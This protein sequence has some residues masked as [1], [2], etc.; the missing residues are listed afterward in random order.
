MRVDKS[1]LHI[2]CHLVSPAH[3][4]MNTA[5]KQG[6]NRP[7]KA[8]QQGLPVP[9]ATMGFNHRCRTSHSALALGPQ[10]ASI[11]I[12]KYEHSC[13]PQRRI[14]HTS[15]DG[16]QLFV[17]LHYRFHLPVLDSTTPFRMVVQGES[18]VMRRRCDLQE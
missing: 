5:N 1:L 7:I 8:V 14:F 16:N 6:F 10:V 18:A 12:P 2:I 9:P 4:D 11:N 13:D 17:V 3:V 15:C